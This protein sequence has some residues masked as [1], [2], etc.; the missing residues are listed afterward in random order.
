[1]RGGHG[2][3]AVAL[4]AIRASDRA[5]AKGGGGFVYLEVGF[6]DDRTSREMT[7]DEFCEVL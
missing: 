6:F 5:A 1:V 2:V 4:P 3:A 7:V